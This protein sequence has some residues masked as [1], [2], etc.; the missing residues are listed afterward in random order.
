MPGPAVHNVIGWGLPGEFERQADRLAGDGTGTAAE[1]AALREAADLVRR[2]PAHVALGTQGPDFLFFNVADWDSPFGLVANTY[3]EVVRWIEDAKVDLREAFPVIE[4]VAELGDTIDRELSE[5]SSTY[6]EFVRLVTRLK[7]FVEGLVGTLTKAVK[8]LLLDEVNVYSLLHHPFQIC[9][10]TE[11]WWWFDT[12][13][14]R[15]S[16][17]FAVGLLERADSLGGEDG[18][19]LRAYAI[20]YLSHV[21]GDAIGHPYVNTVV[22]GPYRT[23][24]QRHKVVENY[25]D[26]WAYAVYHGEEPDSFGVH[27]STIRDLLDELREA[28]ELGDEDLT[29]LTSSWLAFR[30]RLML[31]SSTE[32]SDTTRLPSYIAEAFEVTAAE[33]YGNDPI[34]S[35]D[36]T[37]LDRENVEDAYWSWY[38]WFE[39]ATTVG[40]MEAELPDWEPP[41]DP[42]QSAWDAFLD[43]M[44]DL[45]GAFA[46][47][48][49]GIGDLFEGEFDPGAAFGGVLN[50]VEALGEAVL[51][52]GLL[53]LSVVDYLLSLPIRALVEVLGLLLE[54]AYQGL[55]SAWET[56]HQMVALL[57]FGYPLRHQ[58][59]R[60][61]TEHFVYPF[62]PD[63]LGRAIDTEFVD[64]EYTRSKWAYPMRAVGMAGGPQYRFDEEDLESLDSTG[65]LLFPYG[66]A[67]TADYDE[68]HDLSSDGPIDQPVPGPSEYVKEWPAYYIDGRSYRA[69]GG[70]PTQYG[71]G[72]GAMP[73]PGDAGEP[74]H[75]T[76]DSAA[77]DALGSLP[78]KGPGTDQDAIDWLASLGEVPATAVGLTVDLYRR[79]VTGERVPDVNLDGDRG[80]G[81][82]SWTPAECPLGQDDRLQKEVN[83]RS[84][85]QTVTPV[86]R[87]RG[88]WNE[89]DE[90]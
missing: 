43:A 10:N 25:Q 28:Q 5:S 41:A 48:W 14:Y 24:A 84:L 13:H 77:I 59:M 42:T 75:V 57:G 46:D 33:L 73:E 64:N 7:G 18:D 11:K 55:Y 34:E 80:F 2:Y 86:P 3:L 1:V 6:Q 67:N 51:S 63:A 61:E 69:Q 60:P 23:H 45:G 47:L 74:M 76:P 32:H 56:F 62:R 87:D 29:D 81:Y 54:S 22:R 26:A 83:P 38:R 27:D 85:D 49:D 9:E 53:T 78:G 70:Q 30:Q 36:L 72:F 12:L 37:R 88:K 16:G 50:F 21:A 82:G 17:Q 79:T 39:G 35:F 68:H 90:W 71:D 15:K 89:R 44:G 40:T 8:G 58:I 4:K 19:R 52:Y 66:T 31:E 65:H 20:G